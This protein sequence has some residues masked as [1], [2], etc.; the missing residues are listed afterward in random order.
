MATVLSALPEVLTPGGRGTLDALCDSDEPLL[1]G[2]A[3]GAA[4]YVWEHDGQPDR[5][6]MAARRMLDA[7]G[8]Q[9]I[10]VLRI[11]PGARFAELCLQ[12]ELGAEAIG[13]MKAALEALEEYGAWADSI[14]L[15]WGIMLACLQAGDLDEAEHWLEQALRHQPESAASDPFTPDL[16]ARAEIALAR[17]DI[18]T[19]LGLW[20]RAL[21]RLAHITNPVPGGEPVMEAWGPELQAVA[22]TARARYGRTAFVAHLPAA[23]PDRLT[24]LL[25][26]P[27]AV[28]Q[29]Y[30]PLRGALLLALGTADL[31]NG[32]AG[33]VRLIAL[34]QRFRYLRNFQPTMSSARA[35]EDAENA[36]KALRDAALALVGDRLTA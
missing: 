33:G 22:A 6:A 9:A 13:P 12:R 18:E 32:Q 24:N 34:A 15:R 19:G 30:F 31:A 26:R 35:R 17:G 21:D 2:I 16:G 36:D 3:N 7:V 8:D 14:G 4:S 28:R 20:R 5:A 27:P 10:P 29:A 25:N 23:F 11:W 1:A